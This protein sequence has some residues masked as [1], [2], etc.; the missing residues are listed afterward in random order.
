MARYIR[1]QSVESSRPNRS[2]RS[3][4]H[5]CVL[6]GWRVVHPGLLRSGAM[7]C[8]ARAMA[9]HLLGRANPDAVASARHAAARPSRV[10]IAE[11]TGL[12]STKLFEML[13]RIM[14]CG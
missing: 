11:R 1:C 12:R 2:V 4:V 5:G 10:E 9:T 6:F 3:S 14:P 7:T 8:G 13:A